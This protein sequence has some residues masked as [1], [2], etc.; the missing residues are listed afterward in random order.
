MDVPRENL[1]AIF[2]SQ[3]YLAKQAQ[4]GLDKLVDFYHI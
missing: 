1:S 3:Y 4:I 2:S